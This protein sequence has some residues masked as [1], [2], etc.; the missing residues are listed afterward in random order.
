MSAATQP[1]SRAIGLALLAVLLV[2]AAL[3]AATD[4]MAYLQAIRYLFGLDY[5][6]GIVWQQA[7][8]IP[9]PRMYGTGTDLPFIV[10]HYPPLYHLT[11][12]LAAGFIPDMLAAGR[13]VSAAST[14]LIAALVAA[15]VLVAARPRDRHGRSLHLAIAAATGL[16][17]LSFHPVLF[18]GVLMRVDMMAIALSLAGTLVAA[19]ADGGVAGTTFALLLCVASVFTK[20]SEVS[21]GLAI[22][23]VTLLRRPR[24]ALLAGSVALAVGLAATAWLQRVTHGGFLL[25]IVGYNV[26]RLSLSTAK[27]IILFESGLAPFAAVMLAGAAMVLVGLAAG[28][29]GERSAWMPRRLLRH[30]RNS[31][32]T[33]AARAMLLLYF[34]LS[35]LM[36]ADLAKSGAFL[37]YLIE[38]LCVGSVLSGVLL[39]DLAASGLG[40]SIALGVLVFGVL[41]VPFTWSFV[42]DPQPL[43][44]AREA[45]VRRIA[46][47][48]APVA[49]ED[50]TL[51]LR[52]GRPVVFEPAIATELADVGSWDET[53]LVR[54]IR[55][56]GFAFMITTNNDPD[57]DR[58]R[59]PAVDAAM[60]A[61]YP[62]AE[63][64]APGL[65]LHLPG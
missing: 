33:D 44:A 9:G 62:R 29:A 20:Q 42:R 31:D 28:P 17:T 18:W 46:A 63:R 30:V 10:F 49:S 54:M 14:W 64:V 8:L 3:H 5:G 36:L 2:L 59:T 34:A 58:R 61:A 52:A 38:W 51:L 12:R 27:A 6:E 56:G 19:R 32:R 4:A 16:L 40:F 41:P 15:L 22:G 13:L 57:D 47:A 24:A 43:I 21:A 50:M 23:V 48:D 37:N 25:N 53:A 11:V 45:L 7:L 35:T 65:W 60:R 26:N 55:A 1:G 39:C